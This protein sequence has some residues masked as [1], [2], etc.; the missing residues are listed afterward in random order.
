MERGEEGKKNREGGRRG[1]DGEGG[2]G[3]S[4]FLCVKPVEFTLHFCR[5]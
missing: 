1:E 3:M 4:F 2:R 5:C